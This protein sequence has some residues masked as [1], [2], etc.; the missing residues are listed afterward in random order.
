M[1]G[2]LNLFC[3]NYFILLYTLCLISTAHIVHAQ[4]GAVYIDEIERRCRMILH[5]APKEVRKLPKNPS[6]GGTSDAIG[7]VDLE[8]KFRTPYLK[9]TGKE[10][11]VRA[12]G[13][14]TIAASGITHIPI[15]PYRE[16]EH[17][18]KLGLQAESRFIPELHAQLVTPYLNFLQV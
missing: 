3:A 10:K 17:K 4:D 9:T 8:T 5:T 2:N 6:N 14:M 12:W 7:Y 18:S 15:R 11:G 1:F 16:R 13:S